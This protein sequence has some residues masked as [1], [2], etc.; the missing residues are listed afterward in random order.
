MV[1]RY[2]LRVITMGKHCH[3]V[4]S[5]VVH[6]VEHSTA[7]L[8]SLLLDAYHKFN[9]GETSDKPTLRDILQNN[10]FVLF[11]TINAIKVKEKL[12]NYSSLKE[13]VEIHCD[14]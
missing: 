6:Q 4:P 5:Y 13:T 7:S 2:L 14:P 11:K 1:S 3:N 10:W 8:T 12:R 9:R